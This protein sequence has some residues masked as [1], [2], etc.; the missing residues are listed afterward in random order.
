M[1]E[2][3]KGTNA[4]GLKFEKL[5]EEIDEVISDYKEIKQAVRQWE[6]KREMVNGKVKCLEEGHRK[7]N[8]LIFG[9]EERRGESYFDTCRE[10]LS[11][12]P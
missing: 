6:E 2:M 10:E 1:A 3:K 4:R 5:T 8:I 9:L 12:R 7:N 11:E